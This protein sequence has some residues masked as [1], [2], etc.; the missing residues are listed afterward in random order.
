M[1]SVQSYGAVYTRRSKDQ[2]SYSEKWWR[3]RT[4]KQALTWFHGKK[5]FVDVGERKTHE[6]F[7][8]VRYVWELTGQVR[9]VIVNAGPNY[10]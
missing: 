7:Y 10:Q 1:D 8:I 6:L 5:I 2:R 4:C 3:W 9:E